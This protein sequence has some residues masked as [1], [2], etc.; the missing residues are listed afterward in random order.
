LELTPTIPPILLHTEIIINLEKK[1]MEITLLTKIT[2]IK[3]VTQ[4][5]IIPQNIP[6]RSPFFLRFFEIKNPA[7]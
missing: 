2:L 7:K 3:N 6:V 1:P 5:I 4:K